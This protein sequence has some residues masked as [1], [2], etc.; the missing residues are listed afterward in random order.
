MTVGELRELIANL[1]AE[2]PIEVEIFQED[3][4]TYVGIAHEAEPIEGALV[5]S[6]R[7]L[8]E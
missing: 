3:G 5:F 4:T 1:D 6:A 8:V 2:M 7:E